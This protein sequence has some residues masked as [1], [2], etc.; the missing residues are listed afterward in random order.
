MHNRLDKNLKIKDH[1]LSYTGCKTYKYFLDLPQGSVTIFN[2]N[3]VNDM[4]TVVY[5]ASRISN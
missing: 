1:D 4:Y 3:S 2:A 5:G